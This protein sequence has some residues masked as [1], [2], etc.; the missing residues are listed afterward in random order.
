MWLFWQTCERYHTP[1]PF[2]TNALILPRMLRMYVR[3]L[4]VANAAAFGAKSAA[5]DA[6][7]S[8]A[9]AAKSQLASFKSEAATA[10]AAAAEKYDALRA[11]KAIA[12]A[13]ADSTVNE[14]A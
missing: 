12:D 13:K 3:Q 11:S 6:A 5:L 2:E 4:L 9:A 10:A 7:Q 8:A 14:G 1:T